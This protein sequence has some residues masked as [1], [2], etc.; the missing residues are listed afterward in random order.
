MMSA[1]PPVVANGIV[2]VLAAGEFTAQAN[3]E[4]GGLY[5]YEQRIQHSIPAKLYALDAVTG[6]EL[7]SSGDQIASFLHQAGIAVADGKV[8]FGTFDGTIYCFG[9]E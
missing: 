1:E 7:Y 8:I 9:L 5:S 4:D 3:D 6:K 2:F